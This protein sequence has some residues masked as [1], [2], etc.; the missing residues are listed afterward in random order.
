MGKLTQQCYTRSV[1]QIVEFYHVSDI[2]RDKMM[3]HIHRGK[4]AKD[5]FVPPPQSTLELLR[6]YWVSHRNPRL[7][8]PARGLHGP[9][10]ARNNHQAM[11]QITCPHYTNSSPGL[12]EQWIEFDPPWNL[13]W[14]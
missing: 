5:R 7:I 13:M 8:F 6:R 3:I 2:E 14:L 9:Q 11:P 4:G 1:R 12:L 10:S